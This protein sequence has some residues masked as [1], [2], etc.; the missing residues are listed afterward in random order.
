MTEALTMGTLAGGGFQGEAQGGGIVCYC[1]RAGEV[2]D[3]AAALLGSGR[4]FAR[5]DA[6][7]ASDALVATDFV[8]LAAGPDAAG[9]LAIARR[10][11]QR[12]AT[13]ILFSPTFEED[14]AD[15]DV[16][17]VATLIVVSTSA[18]QA[19]MNAAR[20]CRI[21]NPNSHMALIYA[22]T[23]DVIG[24]R[25]EAVSALVREFIELGETFPAYQGSHQLFP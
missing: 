10:D 20:R 21:A 11:A 4:P 16:G 18:T 6:A 25:P 17:D 12:I 13:L 22:E 15:L 23:A 19:E 7:G 14:G 24:E 9:A 1:D 5:I 8:L 3:R 2:L